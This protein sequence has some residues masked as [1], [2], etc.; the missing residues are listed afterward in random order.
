MMLDGDT[1]APYIDITMEHQERRLWQDPDGNF[2][3]IAMYSGEFW[4]EAIRK[5]LGVSVVRSKYADVTEVHVWAV[6]RP[7]NGTVHRKGVIETTDNFK[8]SDLIEEYIASIK[9]EVLPDV[10]R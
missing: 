2:L 4:C 9:E 3:M 8:T 10:K 7:V 6:M 5:P 1:M